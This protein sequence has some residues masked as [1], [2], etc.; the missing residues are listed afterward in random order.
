VR[1]GDWDVP[2]RITRSKTRL[3]AGSTGVEWAIV[4]SEIHQKP[5]IYVPGN[6]EYYGGEMTTALEAM[7]ETAKGTGV[8]LLANEAIIIGGT[9]FLGATLW[10]DYSAAGDLSKHESM[11]KIA[12]VL[13]DH[14]LIK[15]NGSLFMPSDAARIHSES[16]AWLESQLSTPFDGP[17]VIVTHHGPTPVAHHPDFPRDLISGAFW[18]DLEW[19]MGDTVNLWIYGHTHSC[20][21]Q[22]VR[23]TRV[24]S[25]QQGYRRH[26]QEPGEVS[27]FNPCF[28]AEI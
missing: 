28:T 14:H 5:V 9:R 13:A 25:N 20:L 24:V 21:D 3:S 1:F 27:G 8:S 17:T 22:T 18:S 15:L 16:V 11:D 12:A 2:K 10:T 7:R 19:L 26:I 6:H 23:G 4:E